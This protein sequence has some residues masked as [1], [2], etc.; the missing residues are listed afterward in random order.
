MTF[1]PTDPSLEA[2]RRMSIDIVVA[3]G[4]AEVEQLRAVREYALGREWARVTGESWN[5]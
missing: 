2:L 3:L 1:V 5:G 4:V